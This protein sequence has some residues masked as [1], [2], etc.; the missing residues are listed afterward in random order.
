[1]YWFSKKFTPAEQ[2]YS[3]T[4]REMM[5][6]YLGCLKFAHEL[7][8]KH[9][10]VETDHKALTYMREARLVN[11]DRVTRWLGKLT[12]FDF[13]IKYI[14]GKDMELADSVSR[15]LSEDEAEKAVEILKIHN[16]LKHRDAEAVLYECKK[17][18]FEVTHKE[19][20]TILLSCKQCAAFNSTKK[21]EMKGIS[22]NKPFEVI[23]LDCK[24]VDDK[25]EAVLIGID[26]YSRYAWAEEIGEKT[27]ANILR[28]LE[29]WFKGKE[30]RIA[31]LV[32]DAGKEFGHS[33]I[34]SWCSKHNIEKHETAIGSHTS[35]G[36]TERLIGTLTQMKGK[37]KEKSW[38]KVAETYNKVK[39]SV[40]KCTP[41]EAFYKELSKE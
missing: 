15:G 20:K 24:I 23:G 14:K 10:V 6:V 18:G 26:F 2:K 25:H 29:K 19:I 34:R 17:K 9:F 7:R 28:C 11:N 21:N 36:R 3:I 8:G 40:I 30:M 41:E 4:E 32:T 31:K 33:D 12:Q 38:K 35:N 27:S 22:A 5:A 39:H 37:S 13:E 1:M 16:E